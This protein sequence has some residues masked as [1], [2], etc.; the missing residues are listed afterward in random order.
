MAVRKAVSRE[1]IDRAKSWRWLAC[2]LSTSTFFSPTALPLASP[3]IFPEPVCRINIEGAKGT[4]ILSLSLGKQRS[5]L[6][7]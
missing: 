6:P 7:S 2:F 1:V 4:Q 5:E 3:V